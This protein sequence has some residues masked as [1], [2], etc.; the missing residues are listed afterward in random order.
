MIIFQRCCNIRCNIY[1]L[2]KI[3]W[4]RK[5]KW[6][7]NNGT[8]YSNSNFD[9]I[10]KNSFSSIKKT[11]QPYQLKAQVGSSC[12][13]CL[14]DEACYERENDLWYMMNRVQWGLV[15]YRFFFIFSRGNFKVSVILEG[16]HKHFQTIRLQFICIE[17]ETPFTMECSFKIWTEFRA[18]HSLGHFANNFFK[19]K[20]QK[21]N[22]F[23]LK[24]FTLWQCLAWI[25]PS[26]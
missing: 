18:F 6:F 1:L 8:Q 20:I 22:W 10:L 21:E 23:V 25:R 15:W 4:Y 12:Q 7:S 5:I 14:N 17:I 16:N 9:R 2:L 19:D 13:G 24:W 3:F 11:W 26:G